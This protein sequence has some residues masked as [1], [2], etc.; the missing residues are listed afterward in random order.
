[1]KKLFLIQLF[2]IIAN[3]AIFAQTKVEVLYFKAE[4]TCCK[5]GACNALESDIQTMVTENYKKGNVVF[6]EVKI[7]DEANK[8]L[9]TKY[10]AKS[11]T[12]VLVKYKKSKVAKTTDIS[13]E[14]KQYVFDKDK[15]A[16]Q[17]VF[18]TK[19]NELIK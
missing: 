12:V 2:L 5:A 15:T 6:K 13:T 1:M 7:A 16:F 19:V 10:N 17:T 11:Q 14:V 4:L 18:T 8:E 9:V 3:V